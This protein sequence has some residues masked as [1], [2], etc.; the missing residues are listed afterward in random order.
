VV[1][2]LPTDKSPGPDGFTNEFIKKCWHIIVQD[3]YDL[4]EAFHQGSLCLQSLNG[5]YITLIPKNDGPRYN[6]VG[7]F[8]P[9]SLLNS[10]MKIITK[11]L[12]NR[13]HRVIKRLIHKNQYGF[14]KSRIIQDCLA[15]SFEYLHLCHQSKK[16]LIILKLDFEKDFDTVEHKAILLIMKAMVTSDYHGCQQSSTEEC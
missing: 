3:F 2:Q 1:Q 9:I 10:S 11:L 8:R 14:I 16:E 5:S 15:W 12:S 4:I 6:H 7:G 13:L